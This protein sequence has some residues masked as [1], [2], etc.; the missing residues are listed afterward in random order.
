MHRFDRHTV[1]LLPR[2]R[3][4]SRTQQLHSRRSV[5][6]HPTTGKTL[7]LA[8]RSCGSRQ[9]RLSASGEWK[10]RWRADRGPGRRRR[11]LGSSPSGIRGASSTQHRST[12]FGTL[13]RGAPPSFSRV[14]W[15]QQAVPLEEKSLWVCR[16]LRRQQRPPE[17][18]RDRARLGGHR[19]LGWWP[20]GQRREKGGHGESPA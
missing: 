7:S 2:A 19:R 3:P 4:I 18:V 6:S 17:L 11:R 1:L 20:A 8:S 12:L 14:P 5:L 15:R 16:R 13:F 9:L 10:S